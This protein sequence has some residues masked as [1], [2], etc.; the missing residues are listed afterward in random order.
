LGVQ[1]SIFSTSRQLPNPYLQQW[2]TS[3]EFPIRQIF[4]MNLS[5]FG[6]KGTRLRRQLNLNQPAPG[7]AESLDERRPFPA[8]KNIFQFETSASS[9]AHAAAMR[10]E[11]PCRSAIGLLLSFRFSSSIDDLHFLS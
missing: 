3:L 10:A 6:Q 11:R 9:I 1:P 2:S 8:F 4:L 5:Y 7:S